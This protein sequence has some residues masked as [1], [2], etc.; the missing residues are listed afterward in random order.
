M[1]ESIPKKENTTPLESL[2]QK[3]IAGITNKVK[4]EVGGLE[5]EYVKFRRYHRVSILLI[6]FAFLL[7]NL[8]VFL[9]SIYFNNL[10]MVWRYI[11]GVVVSVVSLSFCGYYAWRLFLAGRNVID[12]FHKGVDEIV[13]DK[14]FS[15]FGLKGKLVAHSVLVDR[16]PVDDTGSKWRQLYRIVRGHVSSLRESPETDK[17]L[18]DLATSELITEPFNKTRIDSVFEIDVVGS[19]MRVA[20][21]EVEQIDGVGRKSVKKRLFKGYFVTYK[22]AKP[23]KGKTFVSTEGD[24]YGFAHRTYWKGL[25]GGEVKEVVFKWT[26]FENLLHVASTDEREARRIITAPFMHDLYEWWN[27]ESANI[28]ISFMGDY[29]YLLF[30]DEQIRFEETIEEINEKELSAYL[31]TIARPLLSVLHLIEHVRG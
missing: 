25:T 21:L 31:F 8:V 3:N 24:L 19:P 4:T 16:R 11:V 10:P 6:A 28:R 30:P 1:A 20:E 15:L 9:M 17:V 13:Y 23:C 26:D 12:R 29:L 22:L 2:I 7:P 18:G 5:R 27:A 14:V